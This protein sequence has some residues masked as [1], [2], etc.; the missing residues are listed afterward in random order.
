MPFLPHDT[1]L[2]LLEGERNRE[3]GK[4]GEKERIKT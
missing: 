4:E 2:F 3:N 1:V